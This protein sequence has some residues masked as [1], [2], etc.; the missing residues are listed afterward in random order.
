VVEPSLVYTKHINTRWTVGRPMPASIP[1]RHRPE[2]RSVSCTEERPST[3]SAKCLNNLRSPVQPARRATAT[4][5]QYQS[6]WWSGEAHLDAW[7]RWQQVKPRCGRFDLVIVMAVQHEHNCTRR[8]L[9]RQG[10]RS[11]A[12]STHHGGLSLAPCEA[13]PPVR[14]GMSCEGCCTALGQGTKH[15]LACFQGEHQ[16]CAR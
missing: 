1:A 5:S 8:M 7:Q 10:A 4:I 12:A 11:K 14:F 2:R 6:N 16:G 3:A 15:R 13:R 9:V